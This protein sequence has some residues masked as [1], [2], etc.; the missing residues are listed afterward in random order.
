[1]AQPHASLARYVLTYLALLGL[2]TLALVLSRLPPTLAI[3]LSLAIAFAK[4]LLVL[5]VFM[6]LREERFSYRF[7]MLISTV[8]VCIFVALTTLDP[9][10]RGPYPPLPSQNPSYRTATTQ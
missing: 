2:A 5:A 3:V 8:L 7:V 6:H 9:L 4:A 1:M 10:T